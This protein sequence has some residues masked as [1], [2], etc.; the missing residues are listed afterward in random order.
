MRLM[1]ISTLVALGS[2]LLALPLIAATL[3]SQ[4]PAAQEATLPAP[5]LD[6][7]L[8][9]GP[10]QTAVLAGGCFWGMEAVF[11]QV[12]GVRDVVTGYAGGAQATAAYGPVSAGAT[13]HAEG[14]RI[15]YDPGKVTYGQLLQVYFAVAHDP[16]QLN[17]QGPDVGTQYRSAIFSTDPAQRQVARAYMAQLQKAGVYD[18]PIV[19]RLEG[20]A[21]FYPAEP[22]HQNF[23][24]RN[25]AHP[26]VVVHD[27][28]KVARFRALFPELAR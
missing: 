16:T 24:A 3:V 10:P 22:H 4:R 6:T 14:I 25:P 12:K 26:Y 18:D 21:T 7:R 1:K 27:L 15:T 17:R 19:T 13:G 20:S 8:A 2:S 23:V 5:A 11:E 9:P 28:P